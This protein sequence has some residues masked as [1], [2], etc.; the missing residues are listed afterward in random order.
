MF[1]PA[2]PQVWRGGL[3]PCRALAQ[4]LCADLGAAECE[5]WNTS[6]CHSLGT[7]GPAGNSLHGARYVIGHAIVGRLLGWDDAREDNLTC[8][9]YLADGAYPSLITAIRSCTSATRS[10]R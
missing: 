7:T 8:Q 3:H 2:L 1:A 9:D 5:T 4:R 6:S 10:T